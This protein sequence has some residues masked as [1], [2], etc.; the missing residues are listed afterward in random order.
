M[1]ADI[2]SEVRR[3]R[4]RA[5][6]AAL[7]AAKLALRGQRPEG[8]Q[9]PQLQWVADTSATTNSS[10]S[11]A[12]A[13]PACCSTRKSLRRGAQAARRR[14]PAGSSTRASGRP[15][16]RHL[17]GA[18]QAPEA[19]AAYQARSTRWT[20]RPAARRAV[21]PAS[22]GERQLVESGCV[23]SAV[24]ARRSEEPGAIERRRLRSPPSPRRL[25]PKL[26]R[27]HAVARSLRSVSVADACCRRSGR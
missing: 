8:R 20:R 24:P 7:A 18:G 2:E 27:C 6:M 9:A 12:C 25:H 5:S 4:L 17:A 14:R 15:Q 3:H 10:R 11:P 13:W 22:T 26:R 21:K 16:G 19:R 1:A 23:Q